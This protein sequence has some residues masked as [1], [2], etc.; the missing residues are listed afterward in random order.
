MLL[1]FP[2]YCYSHV[3]VIP[4][5]AGTYSAFVYLYK[6]RMG[7]RLRGNDKLTISNS[8]RTIHHP[9]PPP[10]KHPPPTTYSEQDLNLMTNTFIS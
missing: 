3:I 7:S 6:R 1:L 5:Q 9:P 8:L 2:R 10:P 4:A